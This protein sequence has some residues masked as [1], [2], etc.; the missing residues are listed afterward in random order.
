VQGGDLIARWNNPLNE[1]LAE[2]W[3]FG[4]DLVSA[5]AGPGQEPLSILNTHD[6]VFSTVWLHGHGSITNEEK[7]WLL[8]DIER[9]RKETP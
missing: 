1:C 7:R 3:A 8:A 9:T 5:P 6:A 4:E 2:D